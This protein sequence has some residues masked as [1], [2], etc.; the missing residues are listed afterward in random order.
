MNGCAVPDP[1]V[2]G[3]RQP[4]QERAAS[5]ART[6]GEVLHEDLGLG[7]VPRRRRGPFVRAR[8]TTA[9]APPRGRVDINPGRIILMDITRAGDRLVTV[10]ERG[11]T[12]VSDD[13]G[14][15]WRAVE[16]R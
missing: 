11:F 9:A 8:R 5:L 15:S 4:R 2:P 6:D 12:L 3:R 13:A 14:Q 10:G 16:R 7:S 1:L